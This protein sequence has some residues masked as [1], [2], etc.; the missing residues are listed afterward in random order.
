[1]T[2]NEIALRLTEVFRT[3]FNRPTLTVERDTTADKVTGWDSLKH[4]ELIVSVE[5]AFEIRFKVI[6]IGRLKNVGDLLDKIRSKV[7]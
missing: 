4:V 5:K 7:S 1:M 2:D 6:E 3:V